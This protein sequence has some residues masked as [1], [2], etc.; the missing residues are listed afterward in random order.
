MSYCWVWK[1]SPIIW[2]YAKAH[3]Y[4][5]ATRDSDFHEMSLLCDAPPKIIWLKSGNRSKVA[6]LNSLV[7]HAESIENLLVAEGKACVEIYG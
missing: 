7:H 1:G 3:G 5:I 2:E 4:V 6:I